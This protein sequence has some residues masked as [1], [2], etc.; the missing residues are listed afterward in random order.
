MVRCVLCPNFNRETRFCKHY[1]ITIKLKDIYK[2]MQ[3]PGFPN[4][5][6]LAWVKRAQKTVQDSNVKAKLSYQILDEAK[7]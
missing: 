1:K 4:V 3:C 6:R 7:P 5:W 2:N